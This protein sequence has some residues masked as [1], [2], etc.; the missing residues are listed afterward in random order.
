MLKKCFE[1]PQIKD[2]PDIRRLQ[3]DIRNGK[4][5]VSV[6][7]TAFLF[8]KMN[9]VFKILIKTIDDAENSTREADKRAAFRQFIVYA[10][11]F[12]AIPE[13]LYGAINTDESQNVLYKPITDPEWKL[14]FKNYSFYEP[15]D[16]ETF[17]KEF[18]SFTDFIVFASAFMS[19]YESNPGFSKYFKSLNW[20]FLFWFFRQKREEQ[21]NFFMS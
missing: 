8:K 2:R 6:R 17:I 4:R 13:L 1:R 21:F 16:K 14:V 9:K 18:Y 3:K 15:K 19:K 11:K 12:N 5:D 7:P 10:S 20:A